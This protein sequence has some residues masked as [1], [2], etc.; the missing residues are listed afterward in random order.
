MQVDKIIKYNH[1]LL[2]QKS[3]PILEIDESVL[4]IYS[5]LVKNLYFYQAVGISA[6]QIGIPIQIFIIAENNH[7]F[8]NPEILSSEGEIIMNE[9]CLSFPDVFVPIRRA[10]KITVKYRNLAG[11]ELTETFTDM[12]A[13]IIAH[14]IC[15]L[16]GRTFLDELKPFK[17]QLTEEKI[18]KMTR[19]GRWKQFD[20]AV[21]RLEKGL[22]DVQS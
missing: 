10:K 1:K 20:E 15:H 14:E 12:N 6:I 13:R 11:I 3:E 16:Q 18:K 19:E 8:I 5:R 9:G 4:D 7:A 17:R 21:D 22:G 2:S